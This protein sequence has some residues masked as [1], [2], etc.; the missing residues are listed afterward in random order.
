VRTL[1]ET[2]VGLDEE[3]RALLVKLGEALESNPDAAMPRRQ[4]IREAVAK[5]VAASAHP[6]DDAPTAEGSRG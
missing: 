4:A 5:R 2:P 6:D 1:V 3:A